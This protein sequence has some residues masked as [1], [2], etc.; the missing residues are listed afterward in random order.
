MCG[1]NAMLGQA[2]AKWCN[3]FEN[4][5]TDIDNAEC[6]RRPL[7][8]TNSQISACVNECILAKTCIAIDKFLNELD[9]S[10]GSV[11]T[12]IA[13]WL[14]FHNNCAWL[15][16]RLLMEEHKE[17]H[18]KSAFDISRKEMSFWTKLRSEMR[19]GFTIYHLKWNT[20]LSNGNIPLLWLKVPSAEYMIM[21]HFLH[22]RWFGAYRVHAERCH[23]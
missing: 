4:R 13:E 23:E 3:M 19:L 2:I 14:K 15:V 12:I 1:E 11:H 20:P 10:Q 16:S 5:H 21:M 8:A 18:F 9:I 17:T 7:T 22:Q 6:K